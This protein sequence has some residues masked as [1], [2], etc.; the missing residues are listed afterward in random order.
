MIT[1][2]KSKYLTQNGQKILI[3]LVLIFESAITNVLQQYK[4]TVLEFGCTPPLRSK[5]RSL[6]SEKKKKSLWGMMSWH[7]TLNFMSVALDQ[8]SLD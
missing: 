1:M 5:F 2:T 8:K 7:K 3:L 4:N 6:S